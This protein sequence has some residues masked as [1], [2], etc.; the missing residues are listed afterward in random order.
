MDVEITF[1]EVKRETNKVKHGYDFADLTMAFFDTATFLD[2]RDGRFLAVGP[3]A[4]KLVSVVF[5]P[6]GSE[7]V[8]VVSMRRTSRKERKATK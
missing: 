2:A 1:D 3:F 7:A 4:G 5:R 8:S 6:L